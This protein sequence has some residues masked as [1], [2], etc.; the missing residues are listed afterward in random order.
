MAD[1]VSKVIED[2][3]K[4][5]GTKAPVEEHKLVYDSPS[6]TLEP[7]YFWFVD[8]MNN[9]FKEVEKLTDNFSSSPGGGHFS[10]LSQKKSIM[11]KNVTETM[12]SIGVFTKTIINLIYDLKDFEIRLQ[13]YEDSISK[14]KEKKDEGIL[15][16]KQ[17]WLDNVDIKRGVGSIH[18][19]TAGN[20][21]FVTLRDAFLFAKSPEQV[22]KMDL[23]ERVKRI[24]KPRLSEFFKWKETSE[25]ELRKRYQIEKQY[26]KNQVNM[27][28]LYTRWFKPYL[29]AAQELESNDSGKNPDIVKTFNTIVLEL[30]L[31]GK[32]K[33]DAEEGVSSGE[34]PYELKIPKR[35]YYEVMLIDFYFRGIP[36]KQGQ[37]Y[38]FG[39]KA[40]VTFKAYTMNS[41]ELKIFE[42]EMA[43]SEIE[44]V[45]SL[46]EGAT[47][48][49]LDQLKDDL[50]HFINDDK[51]KKQEEEKKKSSNDVNPFSALFAPIFK[52]KK[53][54]EKEKEITVEKIKKDS[55]EEKLIREIVEN[56][57]RE[58]CYN[59][60]DIYKKAHR[61]LS[62]DSPF[63][64]S[65]GT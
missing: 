29:K 8:Q 49:S 47:T 25:Q 33:Y 6:E 30:T 4:K 2:V 15:A 42:K 17:I 53:K 56:S 39:G 46:I 31:L 24:L 3:L 22:D 37:H 20:L 27:L 32:S 48:E 57:V 65:I 59:I 23:N 43:K 13:H 5:T 50:D 51:D 64:E 58:K 7:I 28:K 16:L 14:N 11:Q 18:Q 44:D 60:Y 61:M 41:E 55:Y 26:L 19:M 10:E 38:M 35:D 52:K 45:F 62:H 9:F 1:S 21:N 54:D 40:T 63:E 12:Q 36:S 34:L